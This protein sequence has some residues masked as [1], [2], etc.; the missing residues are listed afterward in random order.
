MKDRKQIER[1]LILNVPYAEKEEAKLLGAM[2]DPDM[3]K[4][5]VPKGVDTKLFERWAPKSKEM[6]SRA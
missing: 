5:F 1:A 6:E 3:K 2:W 4:W